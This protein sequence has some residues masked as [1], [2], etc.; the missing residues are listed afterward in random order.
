[1]ERKQGFFKA[2]RELSPARGRSDGSSTG[3]LLSRRRRRHHYHCQPEARSGLA[4]LIEG[5]DPG[6]AAAEEEEARRREG[7]AQ[8]V[9]GQLSRAPSL[10]SSSSSSYRRSDL[11]L[12]LGVMGAPLAP[13]H[14]SS[15]DPL[16]LLSIKDTPI[17]TSKEHRVSH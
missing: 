6:A 4:P 11:R 5:P 2:L 16:P 8:W 13:F 17:V 10:T 3:L 9:R 1:M 15:A 14:V 7:W 12:L